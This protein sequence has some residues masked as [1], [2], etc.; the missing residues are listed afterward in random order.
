[1]REQTIVVTGASSGIGQAIALW[2]A[3]RGWR[4]FAGVR[5]AADA[6]ALAALHARITP[7]MLDVTDPAQVTAAAQAVAAEVGSAGLDALVNNAGVAVP[8]PVEVIPLDALRRQF[9]INVIGVVSVT[10]AFIPLLKQRGRGATI[11][12]I[13]STSAR[14]SSPLTGAYSAS[15]MA[16]EGLNDSLRIELR[17]WGVRVVSVQPGPVS[18]PIWEKTVADSEKVLAQIP[19]DKLRPYQPLIDFVRKRALRDPR[20]PPERVAAVVWR[21]VI[22]PRARVRYLVTRNAAGY[23][24][25]NHLPPTWRDWLFARV[26]PKW[27]DIS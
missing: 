10:Q 18:T 6:G 11:V 16:L 22:S 26:L 1:M 8:A 15:K 20:F 13:S 14:M 7:L 12:N 4:V 3:Q 27:G 17:P 21:A 23:W 25:L 9:E 2:F 5:K 19:A 24:L